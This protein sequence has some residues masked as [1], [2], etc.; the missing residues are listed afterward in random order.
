MFD[1]TGIKFKW[2]YFK[3]LFEKAIGVKN[4]M[5]SKKF[6]EIYCSF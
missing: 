6:K 1:I 4:L 3:I 5:A 2:K